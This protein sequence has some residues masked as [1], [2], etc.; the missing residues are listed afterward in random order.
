MEPNATWPHA[1]AAHTA[2]TRRSYPAPAD[3]AY[4][5]P[6]TSRQVLEQLEGYLTL[7]QSLALQP[8]REQVRSGAYD[9]MAAHCLAEAHKPSQDKLW[10]YNACVEIIKHH[11]KS[12]YFSAR[13]LPANKRSSIM[14]LYA[15]CRLSDDLVDEADEQGDRDTARSK[16]RAAL[17]EWARVCSDGSDEAHPVVQAWCDTKGRFGIPSQLPEE[18]LAGIRMDLSI[19][20]YATWDDLWVYCYRVAST[21]GLMSM[22]I[23]GTQ[24]MD[25]VPFAIQLG[26]ALQLTNIL[27]D[28]G[29][30][31]KVGRIY[32]PAEDME[33]FGYTEEM[34]LSGVVNRNFIALMNFEIARANT[35]YVSSQAGI[36]MLPPDSRM[37]VAAA[38]SVYRGIL[39]KIVEAEYDVFNYRAHLSTREKMRGLPAVWWQSRRM[40][41]TAT[42][43]A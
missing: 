26:V 31:A 32:L 17:D 4:P 33:R 34:L 12:F 14:A 37:G 5:N 39:G 22:Y 20:R 1:T 2:P 8:T 6:P 13:L 16:A 21:V 42:L 25:A 18:L 35:L 41:Y 3:L 36:A 23:T 24:T 40:K 29:E 43:E 30:D 7:P 28:V 38:S 15:F 27:R 19:S 10:A 9:S 11:S